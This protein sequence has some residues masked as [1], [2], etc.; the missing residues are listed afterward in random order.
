MSYKFPF[1]VCVELK[2]SLIRNPKV[3][4]SKYYTYANNNDC[5]NQMI[6]IGKNITSG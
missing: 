3:N 5:E 1:I 4:R 2:K 6:L